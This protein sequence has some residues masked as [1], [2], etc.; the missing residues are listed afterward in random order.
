MDMKWSSAGCDL[1]S[2]GAT[3]ILRM[4]LH[5]YIFHYIHDIFP[6]PSFFIDIHETEMEPAWLDYAELTATVI[7]IEI[8]SKLNFEMP[9]ILKKLHS[10]CP[11]MAIGHKIKSP[12]A[13]NIMEKIQQN[14]SIT[15]N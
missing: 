5:I 2:L 9:H 13:L 11:L 7:H 3:H 10:I 12:S 8:I 14:A 15:V 1:V 4:S 6:L